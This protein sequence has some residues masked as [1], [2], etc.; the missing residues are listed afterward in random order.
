MI[1]ISAKGSTDKLEKFLH[2]MKQGDLFNSLGHYGQMGVNAL[3]SATPVETGLTAASWVYKISIV[4]GRHTISWHN[5]NTVNGKPVVI[6]LQYGHGTGTGGWVAGR[7]FINP[8]IQ[9]IFDE[10]SDNV[11]KEVTSG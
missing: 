8:A 6:M 11:W 5:T 7:D 10:I 1:S 4:N 9:P 2:K 3:S